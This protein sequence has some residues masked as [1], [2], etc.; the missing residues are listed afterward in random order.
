MMIKERPRFYSKLPFPKDKLHYKPGRL[1]F[2]RHDFLITACGEFM[3][4]G[5]NADGMCEVMFQYDDQSE[6]KW[7]RIHLGQKYVDALVFP[8]NE[9]ELITCEDILE[10]GLDLDALKK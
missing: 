8:E 6:S 2:Q 7:V 3:V 5:P 10:E 9:G 4:A 1:T